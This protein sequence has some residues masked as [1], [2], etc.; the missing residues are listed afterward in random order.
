MSIL[1]LT[2]WWV[3][4][5]PNSFKDKNGFEKINVYVFADDEF[6]EPCRSFKDSIAEDKVI[7]GLKLKPILLAQPSKLKIKATSKLSSKTLNS[8]QTNSKIKKWY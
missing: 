4:S 7:K 8:V 6:D 3:Y 5:K 1:Q 2:S